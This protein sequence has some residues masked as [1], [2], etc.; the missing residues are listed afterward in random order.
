MSSY[1]FTFTDNSDFFDWRG[2]LDEGVQIY[3]STLGYTRSIWEE[4]LEGKRIIICSLFGSRYLF[5]MFLFD[6]ELTFWYTFNP[7][8]KCISPHQTSTMA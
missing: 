2:L 4:G 8:K 1:A 5:C 6:I 3:F 7:N